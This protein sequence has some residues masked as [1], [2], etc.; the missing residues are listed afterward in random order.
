[1]DAV[2]RYLDALQMLDVPPPFTVMVTLEELHG[3][4]LGVDDR[5]LDLQPIQHGTLA[6][7]EI[8]IEDYGTPQSTNAL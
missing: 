7:P 2:P 5:L 6:L 3:A 8:L 4:F 1:M